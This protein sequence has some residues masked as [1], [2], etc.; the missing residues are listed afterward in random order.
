MWYN[1]RERLWIYFIFLKPIKWNENIITA[2]SKRHP[3]ACGIVPWQFMLKSTQVPTL[4]SKNWR[5]QRRRVLSWTAQ[6]S[7]SV[8][9][10]TLSVLLP[11][12]D[13][14]TTTT[15]EQEK[16]SPEQMPQLPAC[17]NALTC[18]ACHWQLLITSCWGDSL[19][20][21]AN[22]RNTHTHKHTHT[23]K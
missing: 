21:T 4:P 5:I 3:F 17:Y 18:R 1:S 9:K 14:A 10:T 19:W 22:T 20:S 12:T 13:S 15:T 6:S 23:H 2:V 8:T 7:R 11:P 16:L